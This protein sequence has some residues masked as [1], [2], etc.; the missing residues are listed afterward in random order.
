M[1]RYLAIVIFGFFSLVDAKPCTFCKEEVMQNESV[2]QSEY[3]TVLVSFEPVMKGHLLVIP[4]RHVVK[5]HEL[6]KEEWADLAAII[7]KVVEVFSERLHTD[8]YIILERNGPRAY[9]DVPHVHFHLLPMLPEMP[10]EVFRILVKRLSREE[11]E[12]EVAQFRSY[13][14]F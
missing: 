11:L 2:F 4:K 3:F 12:D 14:R 1:F 6:C 9:Q 10:T 7:P 5:A 8:Q 13:F